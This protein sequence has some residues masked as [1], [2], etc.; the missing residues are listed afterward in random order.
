MK[1]VFSQRLKQARETKGISLKELR[2]TVGVSQST[3]SH[4][5]SGGVL[6]PLDVACRIAE[7]LDVT[8]DWLCGKEKKE[9]VSNLGDVARI[10]LSACDAVEGSYVG[11]VKMMQNPDFEDSI[12][13]TLTH[14]EIAD[15]FY[16]A[17]K[18]RVITNGS[19][20]E[21]ELYDTWVEKKLRELEKK[22]CL[23]REQKNILL[24]F[25]EK[26]EHE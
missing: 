17:S 12:H 7:A 5:S 1:T 20:D 13:F 4:Y 24:P 16:K 3:M 21:K 10:L 11:I 19:S 14:P 18:F 26:G 9:T 23:T 2:E 6:P 22:S 8:V 15:F 25:D